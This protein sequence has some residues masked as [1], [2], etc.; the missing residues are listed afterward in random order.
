MPKSINSLLGA[1]KNHA[2]SLMYFRSMGLVA[3]IYMIPQHLYE[4]SDMLYKTTILKL[5]H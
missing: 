4:P 1:Y 2:K 5:N 3:V